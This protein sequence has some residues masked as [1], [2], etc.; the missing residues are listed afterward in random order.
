MIYI[1]FECIL[2]AYDTVQCDKSS[3]SFTDAYLSHIPRGF[4]YKVVSVNPSYMKDTVVYRG[5]D[6]ADKSLDKMQEEYKAITE[7]KAEVKPMT[8]VDEKG[9]RNA[10]IFHISPTEWYKVLTY[11][12]ATMTFCNICKVQTLLFHMVHIGR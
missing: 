11:F 4:G 3:I 7:I 9:F 1:D 2:P 12:L 10:K 6:A 8:D 5:E